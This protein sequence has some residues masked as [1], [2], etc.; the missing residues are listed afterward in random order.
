MS[1]GFFAFGPMVTVDI[2]IFITVNGEGE[3]WAGIKVIGSNE[4]TFLKNQVG[5]EEYHRFRRAT[6]FKYIL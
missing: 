1:I 5:G 2:Y 3:T 6:I 4:A